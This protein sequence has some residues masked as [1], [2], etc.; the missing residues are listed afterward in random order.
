MSRPVLKKVTAPRILR[1]ADEETWQVIRWAL[2]QH[3]GHIR[4]YNFEDL[5]PAP[6]PAHEVLRSWRK[7]KQRSSWF[8]SWIESTERL[9]PWLTNEWERRTMHD[10]EIIESVKEEK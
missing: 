3:D 8:A 7:A 1:I 9:F 4:D 10:F 2:F 5:E 6:M